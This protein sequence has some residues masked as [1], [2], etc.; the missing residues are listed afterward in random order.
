M[1]SQVTPK[2]V[3]RLIAADGYMAL[4]MNE[5]AV[6]ELEKADEM[7]PLEGP[8]QL[9]LG[10]AL[11]RCGEEDSAIRHLEQAARLM[12]SPVRSFAWSELASCY[13][14][15]GS[16]ELA[17]LAETLGGDRVYELRIALANSEL[18]I[19]STESANV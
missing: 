14:Q 3:R 7:G 8:R 16:E 18:H 5:R 12:P 17:D 6:S 4:E 1:R 13:R 11:K 2:C 15:T 9:L 19:C 10:L